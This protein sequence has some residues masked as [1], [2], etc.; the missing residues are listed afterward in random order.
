MVWLS[1]LISA[2]CESEFCFY[3]WSGHCL[4][5]FQS[6]SFLTVNFC[7]FPTALPASILALRF[8]LFLLNRSGFHGGQAVGGRLQLAHSPL[9]MAAHGTQ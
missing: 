2:D 9:P 7:S 1:G 4:L 8:L 3:M 6:V 5:V